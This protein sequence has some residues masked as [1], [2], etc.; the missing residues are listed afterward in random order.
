[1]EVRARKEN[2]QKGLSAPGKIWARGERGKVEKKKFWSR[3]VLLWG[4]PHKGAFQKLLQMYTENRAIQRDTRIL[5]RGI[6]FTK[7]NER[8]WEGVT[9]RRFNAESGSVR[10]K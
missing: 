5:D 3:E 9:L 2:G 4:G 10:E 8:E 7:K 1:M 6:I